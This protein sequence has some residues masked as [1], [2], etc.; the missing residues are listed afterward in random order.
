MVIDVK[1]LFIYFVDAIANTAF[2]AEIITPGNTNI[3]MLFILFFNHQ[4]C[5]CSVTVP[6][7]IKAIPAIKKGIISC[8]VI[9]RNAIIVPMINKNHNNVVEFEAVLSNKANITAIAK[10]IRKDQVPITSQGDLGGVIF[11]VSF[12]FA[13]LLC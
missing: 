8:V 11:I 3:T 4:I 6:V 10:P 7:N 9:F 5:I 12:S 2:M 13:I 1:N